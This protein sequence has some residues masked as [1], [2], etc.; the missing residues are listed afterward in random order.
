MRK[1][2]IALLSALSL[3]TSALAQTTNTWLGGVGTTNAWDDTAYW[4]T[5]TI[6][7]GSGAIIQFTNNSSIT[8]SNTKT[9]GV[10]NGYG[11]GNMV[12]GSTTDAGSVLSLNNGAGA[13]SFN[14]TN[15]NAIVY[16]YSDLIGS[17]YT[18]TGS[19]VLAFR[20]NPRD[21]GYTGL[22]N[23]QG[24]KIQIDRD[25]S[26]GNTNNDVNMGTGTVLVYNPGTPNQ[27]TTLGSGRTI[28]FTSTGTHGIEVIGTG[29]M[30][31]NG[32]IA[33]STNAS[34]LRKYGLG[35]LILNGTV[36]YKGNTLISAGTLQLGA[37][38]TLA[39]D[40]QVQFTDA[41]T[42]NLGGTSQS[43]ASLS[44]STSSS[45]A[46]TY[47]MTNGNMVVG[48]GATIT[49]GG[50][51]GTKFDASGLT[52]LNLNLGAAR[53][54]TVRPDTSAGAA[55]NS[56]ILAGQGIGSNTITAGVVTIGTASSSAG[57]AN[58]GELYLGKLNTINTTNLIIGGFNGSGLIQYQSGL[59]NSDLKLRAVDGA[60]AMTKLTV[61]ETSSGARS[62]AGALNL[63][64]GALD[65]NVTDI[66]VGRHVAGA[67]N[68]STSSITMGG[69]SVQAIT[70]TIGEKS[71]TG[72]P[73]L[74]SIVNQGGGEVK[75]STVKFGNNLGA[76]LPNFVS[77]Y[78]L[79]SSNATLRAA[80]I[81]AGTGTYGSGT[82]RKINFGAGT[83]ANYDASTDLII[84]GRDTSASGRLEI[85]AASNSSTRTF[86][87]DVGR[88]ITIESTAILTS[89]GNIVKAGLGTLVLNGANTYSG[90]T[91]VNAGTLTV[92]N[93]SGS[94]TGTG[95]LT[96]NS[97]ATLS[98]SGIVGSSTS[99]SGIHSPGNSPGIQTFTNG[100]TYLSGATF[101]W[102][103]T[104]N[105]TTVRGTAFDG[106]DVNGGTL[107]INTGVANNLVFNGSGSAV[108]W[109]DAFWDSN[110]SW[111][112]FSNAS[113]P[114]LASGSV[115]DTIN[116]SLDSL[117]NDFATSRAGSSFSWSTT[118]N[119]VYLN[120]T[121]P[122]P[123]TY[124]LLALAAA[125]F[126]THVLR[127]RSRR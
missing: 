119:D 31:I 66:F 122:E 49:F 8:L 61:G 28:T 24:G 73:T 37:G 104:A 117:G 96:V 63:G 19:G 77:T 46:K 64:S 70:M 26:L 71:S 112:V 105:A 113:L 29:S 87:A 82:A 11:T 16:I 27:S 69:G 44:V 126:G 30:T 67:N 102:E 101:V 53:N 111:Q 58:Q 68:G 51:N 109:A 110:Q 9:I 93:T 81:N 125:G 14:I 100:L 21:L 1:T 84:S 59:S 3:A 91:E 120:Y 15:A 60:T 95:A 22:I 23:L 97:G 39:S 99:I 10:L 65:A 47:T 13:A 20:Y 108:L 107:T 2:Q 89:T 34:D 38:T 35:T 116:I 121:V 118:G 72:V 74:T 36:N 56:W 90:G 114:T 42:L 12:V 45:A 94:G 80:D 88:K 33:T 98:G 83:I 40:K 123:G 25:G 41:G 92:N 103:L 124:A 18:K 106:V 76:D 32:D 4:S 52:S 75:V 86:L 43:I 127:R 50:S 54:F 78:N 6:P 115:F 17:G 62:G 48:S 5:A 79:T 55:T 85:A 57:T 7:D